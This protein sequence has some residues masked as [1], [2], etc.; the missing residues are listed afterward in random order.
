MRSREMNFTSLERIF[1]INNFLNCKKNLKPFFIAIK[2]QKFA[3]YLNLFLQSMIALMSDLLL[4]QL[5]CYAASLDFLLY[6]SN[7]L[8]L[9]S[10]GFVSFCSAEKIKTFPPFL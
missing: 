8:F 1:I 3:F 4:F 5:L 2:G 9:N 7:A 10:R 6:T